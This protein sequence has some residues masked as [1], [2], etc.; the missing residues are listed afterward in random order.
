MIKIFLSDFTYTQQGLQ[1]EIAPAAVG[2]LATYVKDKLGEQI[3][4]RI[5]K[6]PEKFIKAFLKEK[7]NVVGFSNYA[8]N[9]KLTYKIATLIKKKYPN[10][11]VI[12]GGPN[13]P[14]KLEKQQ[15]FLENHTEMDYFIIKEGEVGLCNLLKHFIKNGFQ[16]P[17]EQ[18]QSVH[19]IGKKK[20]YFISSPTDRLQD[21]TEIPSPYINGDMDEFLQDGFMPIIQTNRGCPFAC[22]FCVEGTLYYNKVR[23]NSIEK[24]SNELKVIG[25]NMYPLIEKGQ[26][27]DLFIAD[28][29]FGMF[30]RDLEIA[31]EIT[32]QMDRN[33]WPQQIS[34]ATGK[35]QKH[36][37]IEVAKRLRGALR[38]SG[39]VQS[40][41]QDVL[42]NIKRK[43]VSSDDIVQ[44]ALEGGKI[45]ALTYSEIILGLPGDT[46]EKFKNT[47]RE[48][49]GAGFNKLEVYT[50]M[51][52]DG[53][54][55]NSE[56]YRKEFGLTT[57]FRVIPRCFGYFD[58]DGE[59]FS[60][61][62][63]EEVVIETKTM[64]F[65]E[66]VQCRVYALLIVL[67]NNDGF[68]SVVRKFLLSLKINFLDLIEIIYEGGFKESN[69]LKKIVDS[70]E[71]ETRNE[72]FDNLDELEKR[73]NDPDTV[74]QYI[75]GKYGNNVLYKHKNLVLTECFDEVGNE[76]QKGL[77]KLL[78]KKFGRLN[79]FQSSFVNEM[80]N[81]CVIS[82]KNLFEFNLPNPEIKIHF[83]YENE[84]NE[85]KFKKI[86]S[87]G[88]PKKYEFV[89]TKEQI[90]LIKWN[91]GTYGVSSAGMSRLL[92]KI[93]L[94]KLIRKPVEI[95]P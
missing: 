88:K 20:E 75:D 16:K 15:E 8:W 50:L 82:T 69:K 35:N 4:Y 24:L 80:I 48:L 57:K 33:N 45:G 38:L 72:L 28:S 31:D 65:E 79:S 68:F 5:F 29:N 18:I 93:N 91:L 89:Q 44:V 78:F 46:I 67:F 52:L 56:T 58:F 63:T 2:G 92:T 40:L 1:S 77:K 66:Y 42:D 7:P 13:Y 36:R 23:N 60:V 37:I 17:K 30:A 73:L 26:R 49:V 71:N 14:L 86:K 53:S 85:N 74:K 59:V 51:L 25:N 76:L 87:L 41:D 34:V 39:S 12:Y 43:N 54:E 32:K 61:G 27:S 9:S 47:V 11:V 6:K 84:I 83:N 95:R 81:W 19:W 64:K 90:K 94:N 22:T 70:F 55:L 62:E 21:L 10:T 3:N